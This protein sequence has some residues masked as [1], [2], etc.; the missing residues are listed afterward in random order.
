[1][2]Q[3][4]YFNVYSDD[5][6]RPLAAGREW[7]LYGDEYDRMKFG[8]LPTGSDKPIFRPFTIDN[9]FFINS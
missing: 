2:M 9:A 5:R 8:N 6:F 4:G 7:P 1:M 3:V